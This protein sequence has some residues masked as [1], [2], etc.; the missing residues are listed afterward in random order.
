MKFS[1][2]RVALPAA[3]A[4]AGCATIPHPT[5]ADALRASARWPESS[6]PQLEADRSRYV[7][8]CS[9]CHAL[10]TPGRYRED[11][12]VRYLER[13]GDRAKLNAEDHAAILRY[14][15][16]IAGRP[17]QGKHPG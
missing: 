11:Q 5:A 7:A 16:T 10:K 15:L 12:W 9:G 1:V 13:M 8:K 17:V 4:L 6:V 14:V 3:A 2:W